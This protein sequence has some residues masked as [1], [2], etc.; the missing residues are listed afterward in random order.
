MLFPKSSNALNTESEF[1]PTTIIILYYLA[2]KYFSNRVKSLFVTK[3]QIV[4]I[5]NTFYNFMK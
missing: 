2:E 3:F 5:L 1:F 4:F